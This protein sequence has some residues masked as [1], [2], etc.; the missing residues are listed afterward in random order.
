M[1]SRKTTNLKLHAWDPMDQFTREEF[2]ENFAAIDLDAGNVRKEMETKISGAAATAASAA[3]EA[4]NAAAAA[5]SGANAAATAAANAQKTADSAAQA[6]QAAQN[7][8]NGRLRIATGSYTGTGSVN[9]TASAALTINIGFAAKAVWIST[10]GDAS[11]MRQWDQTTNTGY[12]QNPWLLVTPDLESVYVKDFDS[13]GSLYDH[14]IHFI[15]SATTLRIYGTPYVIPSSG[16]SRPLKAEG[17]LND[18]ST[19]YRWIA[20]G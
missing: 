1:S 8:A 10:N 16:T 2:N 14:P 15:W 18:S 17:C 13:T 4:K 9:S 3:A 5:Q 6:A 19:V 12:T 20:I 7:T 11:S